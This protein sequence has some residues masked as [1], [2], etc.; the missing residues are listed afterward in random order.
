MRLY[1]RFSLRILG[2][3]YGSKTVGVAMTDPM[4]ITVQPFKTILRDRESKLRKTLSEIQKIV[5]DYD[6]EKIV[7]GLPL[8]MDD[9]EGERARETRTFVEKLKLRVTVPVEFADERLTTMEAAEILDES[10]IKRCEQKKVI[11][12]VAAQLILEQYLRG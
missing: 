11:D 4:G 3:D 10:G 9:T 6:V 2:L 8:N 5:S 12:Q 1:R 7:V